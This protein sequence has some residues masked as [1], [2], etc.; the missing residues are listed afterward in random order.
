MECMAGTSPVNGAKLL[1]L[2]PQCP[3]DMRAA[4]TVVGA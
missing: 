1:R 2:G 3:D 4:K